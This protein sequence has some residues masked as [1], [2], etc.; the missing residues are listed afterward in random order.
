MLTHYQCRSVSRGIF[1]LRSCM[2]DNLGN[3][4]NVNLLGL[5]KVRSK[6]ESGH[7]TLRVRGNSEDKNNF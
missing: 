4:K 3:K 7:A 5:S 6:I 1:S 2:R